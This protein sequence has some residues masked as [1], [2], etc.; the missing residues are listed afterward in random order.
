MGS[1]NII[2]FF[3]VSFAVAAILTS[4]EKDINPAPRAVQ[5]SVIGEF[6]E[7]DTK[8][9][10]VN[11][12]SMMW[13]NGDKVFVYGKAKGEDTFSNLGVLTAKLVED[14]GAR[15]A[16]L[17]GTITEPVEGC[18]LTLVYS[19]I[20]GD[21]APDVDGGNISI[22]LKNQSEAAYDVT[23][24]AYSTVTYRDVQPQTV[25]TSFAFATGVMRMNITGLPAGEGLVD[26][27]IS[28]MN[29][30]CNLELS[31]SEEPV[32]TG[33]TEATLTRSFT[34]TAATSKGASSFYVA[35]PK[36]TG[37]ECT[38]TIN[39]NLVSASVV[40]FT[41]TDQTK[42]DILINFTAPATMVYKYI[43]SG[44]YFGNSIYIAST[45]VHWAPVNCGYDASGYKCGK[46][47]QW[48]RKDGQGLQYPDATFPKG[49]DFVNGTVSDLSTLDPYKFYYGSKNWYSG[50][51]PAPDDLWKEDGSSAY[52]PCPEGWRIPTKNEME[53]LLGLH[54]S[55]TNNGGPG[56]MYGELPNRVFLPYTG[57]RHINSDFSSKTGDGMY[58]TSSPT[59]EQNH[60]TA[61]SLSLLMSSLLT[62]EKSFGQAVRCVHD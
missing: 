59:R 27:T 20:F 4:C 56:Y 19:P 15:V 6:G 13:A 54:S 42:A 39:Y 47:Y 16:D 46:Y 36:I 52:N 29:T 22:D 60:N 35:V 38:L 43:D 30:V 21:V 58:W 17:S 2:R 31:E 41:T 61:W 25:R 51:T 10:V 49:S 14:T 12:F 8:A 48:G 34:S 26:A 44:I 24:V 11:T 32:V 7:Y 9:T 28:G 5:F 18:M 55:Y 40:N 23:F 57:C 53:K 37:H 45:R 3:A 62:V 1:T 50:T 33:T